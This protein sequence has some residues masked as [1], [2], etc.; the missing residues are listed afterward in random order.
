MFLVLKGM[1]VEMYMNELL[2]SLSS[3]FVCVRHIKHI[4]I[5]K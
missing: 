5:A 1:E 2:V 3:M 4:A